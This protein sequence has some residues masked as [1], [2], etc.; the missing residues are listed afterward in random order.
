MSYKTSKREL[1]EA[2]FQKLY[3]EVK[4]VLSI[5]LDRKFAALPNYAGTCLSALDL[6]ISKSGGLYKQTL[7]SERKEQQ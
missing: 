7:K 6:C 2:E 1:T 3:G 5:L 4:E